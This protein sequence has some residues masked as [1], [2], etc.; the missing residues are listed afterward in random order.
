[1]SDQQAMFEAHVAF[2]VARLT[3][4]AGDATVAAEVAAVFEWLGQVSLS[5]LATPAAVTEV[6][7]DASRR[8]EPALGLLEDI[9]D[10]VLAGLADTPETVGDVVS[11][12]D[13]Q[14]WAVALSGM[15]NARSQVL[16]SVTSSSMYTRLVAHVV[17]SGVKRYVLTENVL[18]KR[19]PGASSLVRLGQRGLGAA[20][21]GLEQNI[22]RQL[23]AFVDANISDTVR[24]SKH[25]LNGMFDADL[26]VEVSQEA[27]AGAAEGSLAAIPPALDRDEL[28][29]LLE[30]VWYQWEQV[31][32]TPLYERLVG[33][34]VG[35]F[36]A[37]HG[38]RPVADLLADL[39]VTVDVA[40]DWA[41]ALAGPALEQAHA[42]GFTEVRVRAWLAAFYDSYEPSTAT[43]T[44]ARPRPK[45]RP[46]RRT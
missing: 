21:P 12:H 17:Y 8:V 34:A 30:V 23:I 44:P 9:L 36:F 40:T 43:S 24:E 25:F 1:M 33:E 3:G 46:T 29:A 42:S 22:D 10:G 28:R 19:I 26:V 20:A 45:K 16:E 31:R 11:A 39:G 41:L 27:W 13:V 5:E 37:S 38:S 15:E 4:R 32:G 35:S 2:D 14:R 6:V 7:V 18:A